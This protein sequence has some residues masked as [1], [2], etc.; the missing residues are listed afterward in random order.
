[1]WLYGGE[2]DP[3]RLS[4]ENHDTKVAKGIMKILFTMDTMPNLP[5]EALPLYCMRERG[6]II[7]SMPRFDKW[8]LLV[9]GQ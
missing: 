2:K 6:E 7:V 1:M 5:K 8:G 3:M 4:T 9:E